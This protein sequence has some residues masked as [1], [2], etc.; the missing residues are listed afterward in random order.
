MDPVRRAVDALTA[1]PELVGR[2]LH[3]VWLFGSRARGA[4]HEGSDV[5]L[6]VLCSPV[7]GN[8]RFALADRVASAAGVEVDV[9]DLATANAPLAWEVVTTGRILLERDDEAVERFVRQARFAA[10]DAAR[11]HRMIVLA[12]AGEVGGARR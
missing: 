5:D 3:A 12:T 2:A 10:E 11:R 1:A 7:L 4:A 8:D 6:A 9:I